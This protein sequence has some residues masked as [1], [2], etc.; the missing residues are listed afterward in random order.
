LTGTRVVPVQLH[1]LPV[2][3]ICLGQYSNVCTFEGVMDLF[4]SMPPVDPGLRNT[5]GSVSPQLVAEFARRV[6]H[7]VDDPLNRPWGKVTA[8][9]KAVWCAQIT[10]DIL[11]P[12]EPPAAL[13]PDLL[14]RVCRGALVTLTRAQATS[15]EVTSYLQANLTVVSEEERRTRSYWLD[16]RIRLWQR[17]RQSRSAA[18]RPFGGRRGKRREQPPHAGECS[19]NVHTSGSPSAAQQEQA[20]DNGEAVQVVSQE[21]PGIQ[22]TQDPP[23]DLYQ[24]EEPSEGYVSAGAS[25]GDSLEDLECDV[26][27]VDMGDYLSE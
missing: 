23:E 1:Y 27:P 17:D 25:S 12:E 14:E 3:L 8:A 20:T 18:A 7:L 2:I 19:G 6:R 11:L 22:A 5:R 9:T 4:V 21:P 24:P 16:E 26:D 15:P 13:P 10:A